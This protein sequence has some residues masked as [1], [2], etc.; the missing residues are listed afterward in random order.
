MLIVLARGRC[1]PECRE[2]AAAILVETG[3][4]TRAEDGCLDYRFWT[5]LEDPTSFLAVEQWRDQ[6]ALDAHFTTPHMQA[7]A[8]NLPDMLAGPVSFEVYDAARVR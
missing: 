5:D 3:V 6:G 2:E 1:K 7:F 4:A 8:A